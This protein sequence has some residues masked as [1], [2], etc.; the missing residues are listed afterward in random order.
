[1]HNIKHNKLTELR[2]KDILKNIVNS[3]NR[4]AEKQKPLRSTELTRAALSIM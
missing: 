2:V 3:L 4:R 1:M